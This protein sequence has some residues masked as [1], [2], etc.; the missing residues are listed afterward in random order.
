MVK[1]PH[2]RQRVANTRLRRQRWIKDFNEL[3]RQGLRQEVASRLRS[4]LAASSC[5]A[6]C[7]FEVCS[8][9]QYI[10]KGQLRKHMQILTYIRFVLSPFSKGCEGF[11]REK[12][13][14]FIEKDSI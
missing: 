14:A 4:F 13:T 1:N 12:G 7:S 11:E 9:E 2:I 5:F 8:G 3:F 10:E 6:T